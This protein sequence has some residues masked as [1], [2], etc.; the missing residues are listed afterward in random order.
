MVINKTNI[1]EIHILIVED[2]NKYLNL[3]ASMLRRI[4]IV[5]ISSAQ[6]GEQALEYLDTFG[7]ANPI[8]LILCDR[9]MPKMDGLEF[10][11]RIRQKKSTLPF[12][13]VTGSANEE[14]VLAAKSS[15]VT[16]FLSK[17]FTLEELKKKLAVTLQTSA[18]EEKPQDVDWVDL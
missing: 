9:A 7:D 8:D 4:G 3:I 5:H 10:L 18:G 13:I 2:D 6:N 14:I 12:I 11:H 15:G 16:S 1:K 17:P